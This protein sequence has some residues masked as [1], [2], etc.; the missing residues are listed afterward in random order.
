M[1]SAGFFSQLYC[2][3]SLSDLLLPI[4]CQKSNHFHVFFMYLFRCY[5]CSLSTSK[6]EYRCRF[7]FLCFPSL[8]SIP[9]W[10]SRALPADNSV[11]PVPGHLYGHLSGHFP[12]QIMATYFGRSLKTRFW[13]PYRHFRIW[14]QP[15]PHCKANRKSL[16]TTGFLQPQGLIS[17]VHF[18]S[19][20][21]LS[22]W[23]STKDACF[24][25]FLERL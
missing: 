15:L 3:S 4:C 7:P 25:H 9:H 16:A 13:S 8:R 22:Y 11:Q 20:S 6:S 5:T 21:I 12:S 10:S 24:K 1:C 17:L 2:V 19:L 18:V 14:F 23:N